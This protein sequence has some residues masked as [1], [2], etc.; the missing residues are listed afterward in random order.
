M[1]FLPRTFNGGCKGLM[2][3][4]AT[5]NS[6]SDNIITDFVKV[7]PFSH[8]FFHSIYIYFRY[9]MRLRKSIIDR[10]TNR[11]AIFYGAMANIIGFGPLSE[12]FSLSVN[13]KIPILKSDRSRK[14]FYRFPSPFCYSLI[15]L[16][17][18]YIKVIA[19]LCK[20][21]FKAIDI[22]HVI[23]T[24]VVH[25]L[26]W[27]FP[28]AIFRTISFIIIDP[29]KCMFFGWSWSHVF[30]KIFKRMTPALANLY[31][32]RPISFIGLVCF[33]VASRYHSMKGH[34]FR[35]SCH[36][37]GCQHLFSSFR[38]NFFSETT[39]GFA[40]AISK[41]A[42][43]YDTNV[44]AFAIANPLRFISYVFMREKY[45]K[46]TKTM[47]SKI[48]LIWHGI[49]QAGY[50]RLLKAVAG[51]SAWIPARELPFATTEIDYMKPILNT[52]HIWR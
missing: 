49:L 15:D 35:C 48:E 20:R 45:G 46:A 6:P 44:S 26:L 9:G 34:M 5:I 1:L 21:S 47:T 3:G 39:A 18:I 23:D 12:R 43:S 22:N 32:P 38:C 30:V 14:S 8:G 29:S 28:T 50:K 4:P 13:C 24:D 25:L 19:P 51:R 10:V 16:L 42:G 31:T 52:I 2:N 7:G 36:T 27:R 37:M 41:F 11:K 33:S 17:V 40:M